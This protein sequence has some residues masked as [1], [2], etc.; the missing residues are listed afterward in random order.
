MK[1]SVMTAMLVL[2]AS[3][4]AQDQSMPGMKMNMP[5]EHHQDSMSGMDMQKM[6]GMHKDSPIVQAPVSGSITHD[7]M[8]LQ[9]PED[10]SRKTGSN[11]PAP[12]LLKDVVSRPPKSLAEFLAMADRANPT[13]AQAHSFVQRSTAQAKQAG[14]YPNP[15]V[16]YQG[17]QIQ[18]EA[19]EAANKAASYSKPLC[20]VESSAF[21]EMCMSS[22]AALTRLASKS[23]RFAFITMWLKPSTRRS[24]HKR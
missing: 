12:E 15:T 1:I 5:A 6:P 9:E 23:R 8:N 10:P 18:E 16:G 24:Q 19:S 14:L 21:D 3:A 11:V 7:T 22:R 17:E 13:I 2:A 20:L 4:F